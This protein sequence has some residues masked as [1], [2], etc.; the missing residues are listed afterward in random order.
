MRHGEQSLGGESEGCYYYYILCTADFRYELPRAYFAP[1]VLVRGALSPL[2]SSRETL[3][4]D[5]LGKNT[6]RRGRGDLLLWERVLFFFPLPFSV[7][8]PESETDNMSRLFPG[9]YRVQQTPFC[10]N[11]M[12]VLC[13][14]KH[15][16]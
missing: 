4:P 11:C 10:H 7:S 8:R 13:H 14:N 5:L 6:V 3:L 15:Y 9:V 12:Y 2:V 1:E 16:R